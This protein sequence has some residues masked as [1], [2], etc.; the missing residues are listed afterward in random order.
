MGTFRAANGSKNKKQAK[1]EA[2]AAA[3]QGMGLLKKTVA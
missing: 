1:M 2:A 3:L